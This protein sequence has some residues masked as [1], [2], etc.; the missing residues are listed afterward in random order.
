MPLSFESFAFVFTLAAVINGLGI[1]RWIS[2][3]GEYLRRYDQ[4]EVR[5][6]WVFNLFAAVQFLL[7]ILLWWT[8]YSVRT[9]ESFNFL[10]YLY[11]LTGPILLFLASSLLMPDITANERFDV[12]E[13]YS[14]VRRSYS[15]AFISI[16]LWSIFLWPVM[17][18]VFA[19]TVPF[20]AVFLVL[21][22]LQRQLTSPKAHAAVAV[23]NV[24][25]LIVFI[26]SFSL[27]L[28]GVGERIG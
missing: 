27:E 10:S 23:A 6:Y 11:L 21:A 25:W 18:G 14:R 28:G 12:R 16:W 5:H 1:V 20:L 9:A 24:V 19:P 13:H 4:V 8:L 26:A 15:T 22:I 17:K 3:L 7:H 2:G